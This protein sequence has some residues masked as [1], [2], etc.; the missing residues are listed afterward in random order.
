MLAATNNYDYAFEASLATGV[1]DSEGRPINTAI[2]DNY[3]RDITKCCQKAMKV[4]TSAIGTL[5]LLGLYLVA[6]GWIFQYLEKG[7]EVNACYDT[8]T[9]YLDKLNTS[10]IRATGIAGSGLSEEV[11]SSQLQAAMIDFADALF[12]LDFPPS[13]NCSLIHTTA[14]GSKWNWVNSIYFCATVVTTIG[15]LIW[16]LKSAIDC[17]RYMRRNNLMVFIFVLA[18]CKG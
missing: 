16:L 18:S 13:K 11:I 10:V 5:I 12:A 6:G 14:F 2:E 4:L 3:S 15:R 17:V 1:L 9:R 8:Y 7:N